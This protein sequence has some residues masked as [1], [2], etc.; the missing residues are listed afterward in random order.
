[1]DEIR[2]IAMRIKELREICDYTQEEIASKLGISVELYDSYE[3]SGED[4]P[5]NVIYQLS[6]IY[7]VDF[8]EI[9][10]GVSAKLKTYQV[11]RGGNGQKADRYLG[12]EFKDL[13]YH[14]NNEIMQPFLVT[15]QPSEKQVDL[16]SHR[17]EE[18]NLVL[19]GTVVV[20]FGDQEIVLEKGDS[21]YFNPNYPHGQRCGG[22]EPA[23]FLTMIAE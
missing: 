19:E 13:A 14:F 9:L 16:V 23:T 11:V 22:T 5:I 2:E 18:F 3:K 7:K 21:I 20:T 10:T 17:G 12:Y 6:K 1:M 4:I 8:S 15:L